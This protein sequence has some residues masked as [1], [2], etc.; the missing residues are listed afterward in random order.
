MINS[1]LSSQ[2]EASRDYI[3]KLKEDI[4]DLKAKM[5]QAW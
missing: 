1:K 2:R 5:K 3:K 4:V